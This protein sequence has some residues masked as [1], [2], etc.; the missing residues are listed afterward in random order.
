MTLR[1]FALR[2]DRALPSAASGGRARCR[3]AVTVLA[4][5]LLVGASVRDSLR[6][7]TTGRLG[8]T[9]IAI[10]AEQ[11]F[12]GQLAQRVARTRSAQVAPLLSLS[13][14]VRHEASSKRAEAC[15]STALTRAS[16]ISMAFRP[17]PP[18]SAEVLLS[19][20]LAA[21]LGAAPGDAVVI[22]VPRV[23]DVPLD[24]LHGRRDDAGG[25]FD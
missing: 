22:R 25:R 14:N 10:G 15:R 17:L 4:G 6:S 16:S 21:E 2:H 9:S 20:D 3:G 7:I 5:S 19:P 23:T 24:S 11:P 12:T 18:R 1:Q 8:H 13:G